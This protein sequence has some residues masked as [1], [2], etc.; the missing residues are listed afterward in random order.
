MFGSL[1]GTVTDRLG[2]RCLIEV[3]GVGYWV[4]TGSWQP[5]CE[6]YC[7]L[8]HQVREDISELFGFP[9]IASLALFEKLISISGVGPK[10]A[11]ALLSVG[12]PAALKSAIIQRDAGYLSSAPGI[13][14]KAA[15]KI[16]LELSGKLDDIS[17]PDEPLGGTADGELRL[18]LESLGYR[19]QDITTILSGLPQD[20]VGLENQIKWALQQVS[21]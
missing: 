9:D 19:P 7:V 4:H 3:S 5:H 15:E 17:F 2:S 18:A 10:A 12:T 14:K 8:Y 21:R 20:M 11:L 1:R 13:G 6:C 16:I